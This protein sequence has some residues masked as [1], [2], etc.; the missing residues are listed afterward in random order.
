MN[1]VP[2]GVVPD[3]VSKA[4]F[5]TG[6]HRGTVLIVIGLSVSKV[7]SGMVTGRIGIRIGF[8]HGGHFR[9]VGVLS[10]LFVIGLEGEA[11]I[12]THRKAGGGE[13]D[14][15]AA[16]GRSAGEI[17]DVFIAVGHYVGDGEVVC[18]TR[19]VVVHGDGKGH[20]VS[21]IGGR[22]VDLFVQ[23]HIGYGVNPRIPVQ[24]ILP[25]SK[26]G[27][28]GSTA[29]GVRIGI[30]G[31]ITP[32][33]FGGEDVSGRKGGLVED[34][35]VGARLEV[36][37]E[38]RSAGIGGIGN[39][40]I[41]SVLVELDGHPLYP[42]LTAILNAVPVGVV[43]DIV[44]KARGLHKS[45][46]KGMVVVAVIAGRISNRSIP[47]MQ[48]AVVSVTVVQIIGRVVDILSRGD[49]GSKIR[50]AQRNPNLVCR[51]GLQ[52]MSAGH[53]GIGTSAEEI[54]PLPLGLRLPNFGVY[55]S[56]AVGVP[57]EFDGHVGDSRFSRI[58]D[59][60]SV[61]ISPDIISDLDRCRITKDLDITDATRFAIVFTGV[62][63][64]DQQFFGF[65]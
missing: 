27:I 34:H 2:V 49:P 22:L 12:R 56:I 31:L 59:P 13:G 39:A 11:G 33:I 42:A 53:P 45:E 51:C 28:D 46:I 19:A 32:L 54:M 4:R 35:M 41:G 40:G 48:H 57:P 47:C 20:P 61:H 64:R 23:A 44:S 38:V 5:I 1:A 6:A 21:G 55:R 37:K 62:F 15:T 8:I 3:I 29:G 16:Q 25:R 30:F 52:R 60:V 36:L 43:P 58:L 63:F 7:I 50:I 10:A 26:V 17:P 65:I 14:G 24:V 9:P 18:H